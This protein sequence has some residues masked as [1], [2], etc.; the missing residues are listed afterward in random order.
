MNTSSAVVPMNTPSDPTVIVNFSSL[1][2]LANAGI[3][4]YE[5]QEKLY[6]LKIVA[7]NH[8]LTP[9]EEAE[10]EMAEDNIEASLGFL[11]NNAKRK[12]T[13]KH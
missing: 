12:A 7:M 11:R 3:E 13:I 10:K 8:P 9:N 2:R 4:I 5:W 6:A 1:T